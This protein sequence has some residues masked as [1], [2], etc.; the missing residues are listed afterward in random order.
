[1]DP[2]YKGVSET[3]RVFNDRSDRIVD[4]EVQAFLPHFFPSTWSLDPEFQIPLASDSERCDKQR[5]AEKILIASSAR[6][7]SRGNQINHNSFRSG[8]ELP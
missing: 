4:Q 8:F 6:N 5:C 1:M 3:L 2:T 7:K